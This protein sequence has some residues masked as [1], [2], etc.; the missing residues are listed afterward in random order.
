MQTSLDMEEKSSPLRICSGD[1][2][3]IV[4]VLKSFDYS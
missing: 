4:R 2:F 1:D 3:V